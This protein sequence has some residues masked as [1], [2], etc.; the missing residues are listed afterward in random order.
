MNINEMKIEQVSDETLA[1]YLK[2]KGYDIGDK[3]HEQKVWGDIGDIDGYYVSPTA[4][5][6]SYTLVIPFPYNRNTYKTK[7]Q[8]KASIAQSQLTQWMAK[9]NDGWAPDWEPVGP[10]A[11]IIF[12]GNTPSTY[13][14]A[15]EKRFL[16]FKDKE[17]ANK[18]LEDHYDLIMEYWPLA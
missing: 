17:T 7:A 4:T 3:K 12:I 15:R 8:A 14:G 5:V 18:F 2:S 13:V 10:K 11:V 9:V 16:A 6:R 1:E